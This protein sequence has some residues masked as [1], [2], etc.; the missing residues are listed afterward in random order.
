MEAMTDAAAVAI[1]GGSF[2]P[3]HVGHQLAAQYV[4]ATRAVDEVWLMP[5]FNHPFGKTL[6]PF[7]HR[8]RMCEL[9]CEDTSGWLKAKDVER[10]LGGEGR[11]VDTLSYLRTKMPRTRFTLVIGSD[12][13]KDLP[14]W[15]DFSRIEEL[16][17]VLVLNRAGYP[18]PGAVG[19]P[20]AE[21]SSSEIRDALSRG[22]SPAELVPRKVLAYA[23]EN[24]LY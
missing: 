4:Y 23:R 18:A 12:I 16:A 20:L 17:T 24:A 22:D 1:I 7:E 13:V 5:S 8:L 14:H 21:V 9:L 6:T 2:N 19:P 11:T 3:P 10:T 15:K